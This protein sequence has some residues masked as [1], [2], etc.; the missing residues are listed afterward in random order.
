MAGARWGG[1]VAGEEAMENFGWL[2]GTYVLRGPSSSNILAI[3]VP[4][5][6]RVLKAEPGL[7]EST[8]GLDES[9]LQP[10]MQDGKGAE[11]P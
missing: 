9:P 7:A 5:H 11:H 10:W 2:W 3:P 1:A 4:S 8:A 6:R